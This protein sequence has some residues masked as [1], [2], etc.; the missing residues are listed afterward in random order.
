MT[1]SKK[2]LAKRLAG[3][4]GGAGKAQAELPSEVDEEQP[5]EAAEVNPEHHTYRTRHNKRLDVNEIDPADLPPPPVERPSLGP[6]PRTFVLVMEIGEG[7]RTQFHVAEVPSS[8]LA[9]VRGEAL[10]TSELFPHGMGR[11]GLRQA[12]RV[13]DVARRRVQDGG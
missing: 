12:A 9:Q 6:N 10:H 5:P 2:D 11:Y 4:H 3:E 1:K 8:S 7:L 13:M